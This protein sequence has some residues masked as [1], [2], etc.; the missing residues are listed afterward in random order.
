MKFYFPPFY[1][2]YNVEGI[3]LMSEL[4]LLLGLYFVGKDVGLLSS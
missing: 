3:L 2:L 1:R 4:V